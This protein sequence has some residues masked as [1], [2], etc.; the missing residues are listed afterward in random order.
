MSTEIVK[1]QKFTKNAQKHWICAIIIA[2]MDKERNIKKE[3]TEL[4]NILNNAL[5]GFFIYKDQKVRYVSPKLSIIS[6]YSHQ[7]LINFD[8]ML[9]II[10]PE[11][12]EKIKKISLRRENNKNTPTKYATIVQTKTGRKVPVLVKAMG[13]N[14]QGEK[15]H[16][17]S[18]EDISTE[19]KTAHKLQQMYQNQAT[20][21]SE[22]AHS[23]N[24]PFTII[25]GLIELNSGTIKDKKSADLLDM[26]K[27]EVDTASAKISQLLNVAKFDLQKYEPKFTITHSKNYIEA[28]YAK[29][30]A[31]GYKYCDQHHSSDC[32]CLTIKDNQDVI[33]KIDPDALMDVFMTIIENAYKYSPRKKTKA[34]ITISS[35]RKNKDLIV[36]I[37]DKGVGIR[38]KELRQIFDPFSQIKKMA[39]RHG[40]GLPMCKKIIEKMGGEIIIKSQLN[41][42]TTVKFSLPIHV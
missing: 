36:T 21:F 8:S 13:I 3:N 29:A 25:K 42:G 2:E 41:K 40:I 34:E 27:D 18:M 10:A 26:I 24:T 22:I 23:L 12:H 4:I 6:E 9:N 35:K 39:D 15:M 16:L 20:L 30:K 31:L 11:E 5:D 1:E 32:D 28:V 7:E 14:Y 37:A 33:F 17:I 19:K 38:E